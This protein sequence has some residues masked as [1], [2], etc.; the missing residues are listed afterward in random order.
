GRSPATPLV[1]GSVKT[2]IGHLDAA[3]GIAGLIKV[4]LAMGRGAIPKHL[5]FEHPTPQ[6]PWADFHLSVPRATTPWG[7][8][9]IAGVSSFG[10]G[11]T[12]A[13]LIVEEPAPPE[14]S[15]SPD[16]PRPCH[17]LCLSA[18]HP[19]SLRALAADTAAHI[20]S[21]EATSLED[22][23]DSAYTGRR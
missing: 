9:R 16:H 23:T 2:N 17:L 7:G 5:H 12:N 8:P 4:V 3:A 1:V 15:R 14:R 13:H 6:I 18:R 21:S 20:A 11:G 10:I 22:L 19:Q